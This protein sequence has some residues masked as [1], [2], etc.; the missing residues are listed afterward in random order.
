MKTVTL[1]QL[2]SSV[3]RASS[4][5]KPHNGDAGYLAEKIFRP[6][7]AHVVIY[8]ALEQAIDVGG[9]KYAVV[10][11]KHGCIVSDTTLPGA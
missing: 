3:G 5:R 8:K 9:A 1:S 7:G 11:S 6:S 4:N 2:T 10:C